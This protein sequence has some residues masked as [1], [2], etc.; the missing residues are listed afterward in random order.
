MDPKSFGEYL[1]QGPLG[2]GAFATT[3]SVTAADG[4]AYAVKWLR[5]DPALHGRERFKN[6]AWALG[7]LTHDSI[8]KLVQQGELLGRPYIVMSLARGITLRQ[9]SDTQIHEKGTMSEL[10][11]LGVLESVLSA[12]VHM[13]TKGI[14]HRDVKHDNVIASP[15]EAHVTLVDLGMCTG[16]GQPIDTATFWNAG[17]SRFSPPSKLHNPSHSH[18]NHDVFGVGVIAYL[19]LTNI[20]PW[21][22]GSN[23]DRGNLEDL[24]KSHRPTPIHQLNRQI[25]K[26]VSDVLM[27]LITIRDDVRPS[28]AE[29]LKRIQEVR[30]KSANELSPPAVNRGANVTF[31]RVMRDALHGDVVLT[32]F[33]WRLI[34]TPE[35][36]RLRWIR[37]LGTTNLVYPG[38]EHS[39]FSHA[40]GTMFVASEILRRIEERSGLPFEA[41]EKLMARAFALM[42]D[43]THIAFGH[44]LEDELGLF[45]RHDSN[46][47]RIQ[48]LVLGDRSSL[49]ILLRST[50]YGRSVLA[51]FDSASTAMRHSWL[52]ELVGSPS[53][54]D[55]IDYI[56]R[57][58]MHCGLDHKVDS[59]VFRRFS[60]NNIDVVD[61]EKQHLRAQLYGRKGFRIDAEFALE[62]ILIERLGLFMKVYTHEVKVAAGAM[63]GK[64]LWEIL[65]DKKAPQLEEQAI[66]WMGDNE[67]LCFIRDSGRPHARALAEAVIQRKLYKSA[68]SARAL[69]STQCNRTQYDIRK[70]QFLE[71]G[72][73]SPA[74]RA[75]VEQKIARHAGIKPTDVIFYCPSKAPGLQKVRQY[76]EP[77]PGKEALLDEVH[78][79][80]VRIYSA[81]LRLWRVYVFVS[82]TVEPYQRE[83][84]SEITEDIVGI[85]NQRTAERRQY[86]LDLVRP[87]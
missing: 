73:Q 27:L 24:M 79:P 50:A 13:H 66:E 86:L 78:D 33:E 45:Q 8:P 16:V 52:Q 30:E 36:Q 83:K 3:F 6:E 32:E 29:A 57:D 51:H 40:V 17:A 77:T 44:T 20:Y 75:L 59:A 64:A 87:S 67:I 69:E 80:H 21:S 31:P 81:H 18:P 4:N 74:E 2:S 62:S 14:Y 23:E 43:V 46:D 55:V 63:I 19:L 1:V 34:A 41:E 54:A 48:R 85:P 35:F 37:Q 56:D 38:A 61:P 82:P 12:L 11:L 39:R 22:V 25:S 9:I 58:S 84:V 28:A 53:G 7:T 68:Y 26:V 72:F 65:T 10:R 42:H 47:P 15:S 60:I 76:V 5:E 49:G 71:R 70:N